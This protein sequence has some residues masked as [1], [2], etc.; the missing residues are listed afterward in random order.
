L[1]T[2]NTWYLEEKIRKA[3]GIESHHF[4]HLY[5]Q[6]KNVCLPASSIC[7]IER[8]EEKPPKWR[9]VDPTIAKSW[10]VCCKVK[11]S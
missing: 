8:T 3:F 1:L 5:K 9:V 4:Q 6:K 2:P 10:C 7:G 11:H